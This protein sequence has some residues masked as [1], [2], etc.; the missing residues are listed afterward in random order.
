MI[1]ARALIEIAEDGVTGFR[2]SIAEEITAAIR[3]VDGISRR[4][5]R[6]KSKIRSGKY[7]VVPA[8]LG[9]HQSAAVFRPQRCITAGELVVTLRQEQASHSDVSRSYSDFVT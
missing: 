3:N 2:V 7:R 9:L 4:D 6:S 1:Q 5:C 8:Y